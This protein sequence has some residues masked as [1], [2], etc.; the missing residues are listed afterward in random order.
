MWEGQDKCR[1]DAP[2]FCSCPDGKTDQKTYA[3]RLK[4]FIVLRTKAE[5]L[6]LTYQTSGDLKV[7]HSFTATCIL[8]GDPPNFLSV[9]FVSS[10][11]VGILSAMHANA[12]I[13]PVIPL[14][15]D[16]SSSYVISKA[17][18][19]PAQPSQMHPFI[20]RPPSSFTT[21]F[22]PDVSV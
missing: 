17:S 4:P 3:R 2:W 13:S 1:R 20:A 11:N 14:H 15:P 9:A 7:I 5:V 22:K 16:T 10:L 6:A 12:G 18:S 19:Q 21:L 8:L